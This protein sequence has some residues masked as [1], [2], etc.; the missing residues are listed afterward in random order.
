[1]AQ[2]SGSADLPLH[3]GRVPKW[4]GDRMTRLGAVMCEAIIHHYGREELLRRLAHPFWFQSFGAVMGM[5]WHS[6]GITTSVI[7]ALK[8]GL[9]PLS[10]EL[11]IH[12]CGGR[13]AHSRKTPHE[14]AVIG[15][16]VGF[17]GT[18]LAT[19]SRLVAKVDSAAVQDG[20]D[21]YLHG[22]IVT[23]DGDWVV[24]QQGMNGD[25]KVARR[26]HWLSEGL[27]SFV[28]QPHAAIEGANQ[29]EIVNLTDRRADASRKGQ[30]D[31]LQDLG[32]DRI[33]REF[34]ALER[35]VAAAPE[36]DQ[37]MLPHLVMPAHHD[38]R[39]SDVVM[40]RLHGNM[41]AAAERGPADF[42]ELLLVPGV[43]AR[44]VRA[45]ALVAE[46][47]HGA[48]C[49][50]SDPGRFSLAHG[51]KDRHPFPVPL[52]VYDETIG[53]LKSA[54]HK[55]RLGRDEE[56]GALKRLDDQSRQVER[57]V[58]GPSLKEIVAGEFDQSH[59]LGGRSVFGWEAAPEA[60]ADAKQIKQEG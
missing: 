48:P 35:D 45:L 30:L 21:L 39:E 50:F 6:S 17:D 10:G 3:G 36:P 15:E 8:R 2:R 34:A 28:D 51:G 59:L 55:A 14:L 27:K 38:V 26:Y 43:G 46:V 11:G 60:P 40:R 49:R 32:P 37:P 52:K 13:G 57:Y 42:S 33:L 9:A 47:L 25:S 5:D 19:A 24:V 18:G 20:F 12:V 31:L 58:T 7:G 53:V 29:G 16:R 54:V 44:T 22:F 56:I 41:A 23:D 4:L 1:M